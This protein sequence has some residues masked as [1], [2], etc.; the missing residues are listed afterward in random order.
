M[1][2]ENCPFQIIRP[3]REDRDEKRKD[4]FASFEIPLDPND[5]DGIKATHEFRKLDSTDPTTLR[6]K[7][8]ERHRG[9]IH[10]VLD[11]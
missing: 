4:R 2:A 10:R 5:E 8:L 1:S 6:L 11:P 9:D 7:Q 3:K